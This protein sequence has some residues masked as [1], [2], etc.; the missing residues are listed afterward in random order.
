MSDLVQRDKTKWRIV[1]W[2][3]RLGAIAALV[4]VLL[5]LVG[6]PGT[7]PAGIREWVYLALFPIGFSL[8]YLLGWRWPLVGGGLSLACMAASLI[9]IGRFIA[10][11]P[12]L[13]WSI[14]SIPGVLY[15]IAGWK[16]R[17]GKRA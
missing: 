2:V 9:V 16:L 5:I 8:G 7:G 1:L 17:T 3:A 12:Y 15:V 6:E 10:W 11:G 4:P 14:L 13:I